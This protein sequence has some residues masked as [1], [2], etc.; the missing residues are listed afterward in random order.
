MSALLEVI[1]ASMAEKIRIVADDETEH[2]QRIVLNLGHT[3]GHALEA[4]GNYETFLH[5][6]AVGIGLVLEHAFGVRKGWTDAAVPDLVRAQLRALGLPTE[7]DAK[8]LA[9]AALLLEKDKKRKRSAIKLPLL[10]TPGI[11][12]VREVE[13]DELMREI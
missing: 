12:V 4:A 2:G 3:V 13:I 10:E 7:V 11:V 5:G 9:R 6:E 1:A 8:M